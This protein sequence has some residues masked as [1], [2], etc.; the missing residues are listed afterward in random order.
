MLGPARVVVLS[1]TDHHL[2]GREED[3][4]ALIAGFLDG[5][6]DDAGTA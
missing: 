4:A 6:A 2:A 3:A 1:D 5:L